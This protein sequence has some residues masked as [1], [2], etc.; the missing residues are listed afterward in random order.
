MIS[1]R[2]PNAYSIWFI[3]SGE[4]Y[5]TLRTT[6]IELSHIFG[7]IK[8]VPHVTLI[9]NLDYNEKFLS[10]KVENIAKQIK[11]F[12]IYLDE[13]GYSTEFFQS[14]FINVRINNHLAYIRKIA[15]LNFPKIS[16]EYNPH[17]SLAYGNIDS[18]I[19]ENLK[20]NIHCTVKNFKVR[21]L[22]LAH[23]DEIN[24]KWKV[25]NKFSLIK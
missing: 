23:N 9:S 7:G 11:P 4:K 6:I 19:K 22:Y 13:I 14:F 20:N 12:D 15:Q 2:I 17:L 5:I 8:F 1:S 10:N 3:P 18:K 21:E 16:G 25:I 24:F